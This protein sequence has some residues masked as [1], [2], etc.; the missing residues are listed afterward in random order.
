MAGPP[1]SG[2][3]DVDRTFV[4]FELFASQDWVVRCLHVD[5]YD[6]PNRAEFVG[7]LAKER[8]EQYAQFM[9]A[10]NY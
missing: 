1:G 2:D 7:P 3:G 5:G 8:A 6:D 9:N 4:A 10:R